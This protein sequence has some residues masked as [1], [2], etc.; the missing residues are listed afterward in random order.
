[1]TRQLRRQK[2]RNELK[3][4]IKGMN[5]AEKVG[6]RKVDD[7][8]KT[9]SKQPPIDKEL[10][11]VFILAPVETRQDFELAI[12][13]F[14][15]AIQASDV[16][17]PCPRIEYLAIFKPFPYETNEEMNAVCETILKKYS[18]Y[19]VYGLATGTPPPDHNP[20]N[21]KHVFAFAYH[22]A[23]VLRDTY[24]DELQKELAAAELR[25]SCTTN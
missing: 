24:R 2:A 23:H 12:R 17:L 25:M 21:E 5:T 16:E 19:N 13:E 20:K 3:R 11:S 4:A 1:M 22:L 8:K 6:W 18:P 7:A 15:E 10:A 9:P 14:G